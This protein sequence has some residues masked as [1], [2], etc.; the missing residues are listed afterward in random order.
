MY[1]STTSVLNHPPAQ[2]QL[3]VIWFLNACYGKQQRE[4][5]MSYEVVAII[6]FL[7]CL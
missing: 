2:K 4:E 3:L 5:A 7:A 6:S 1:N